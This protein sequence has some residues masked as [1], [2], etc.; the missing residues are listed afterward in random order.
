MRL[1]LHTFFLT[2]LPLIICSEAANEDSDSTHHISVYVLNA[3]NVCGHSC[4]LTLSEPKL[5]LRKPLSN[6][7]IWGYFE[8][9]KTESVV[10]SSSPFSIYSLQFSRLCT[11]LGPSLGDITHKGL[12][13]EEDNIGKWTE[14][15][16]EQKD[17]TVQS[18]LFLDET[19]TSSHTKYSFMSMTACFSTCHPSLGHVTKTETPVST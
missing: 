19:P 11:N 2:V 15:L 13:H 12:S 14:T 16:S 1:P 6:D 17:Q 5:S 10:N 8:A 4:D 7:V 3:T 18:Y 9:F